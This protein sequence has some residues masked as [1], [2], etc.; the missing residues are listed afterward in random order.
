MKPLRRIGQGRLAKRYSAIALLLV[1]I[2]LQIGFSL[3][4]QQGRSLAL[5]GDALTGLPTVISPK[6]LDAVPLKTHPLPLTL[7]QWQDTTQ[8]G[9]YFSEIQPTEA[10]YLIWSQFPISVYLAVPQGDRRS[11]AWLEA[12]SQAVREWQVYLPLELTD[13]P[14]TANITF[15]YQRPPLKLSPDGQILRART[16][17]AVYDLSVTPAGTLKHQFKI[18]LTPSQSAEYT[19]ATSRHELGHALGIWGHSPSPTD[20]MYFSQVR[21]PPVISPRDVNTLKRIYQ[22]QTRLG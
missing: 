6:S 19:L 18:Y 5:G 4:L 13:Q 9:D 20:V 12:V 7:A 14:E 16:A 2:L 10:G 15:Y 3:A 22:Q 21:Q 11:Q 17:E 1:M 8:S